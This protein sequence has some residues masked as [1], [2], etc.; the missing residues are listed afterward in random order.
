METLS[1]KMKSVSDIWKRRSSVTNINITPEINSPM[2]PAKNA[3]VDL[4]AE[5]YD[6][7]KQLE[8]KDKELKD[9]EQMMKDYISNRINISR[10]LSVEDQ[11]SRLKDELQKLGYAEPQIVR[12]A[13]PPVSLEAHR[14]LQT[15]A[16]NL[17][18]ALEKSERAHKARIQ[19]LKVSHAEEI[20]TLNLD[21]FELRD[22]LKHQSSGISENPG[23]SDTRLVI[24]LSTQ[25]SSL[26]SELEELREKLVKYERKSS[27]RKHAAERRK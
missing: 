19:K 5:I 26:T 24:E 1:V 16:A 23:I 13:T 20:A 11:I 6:L 7:K 14:R 27:A 15:E 8:D 3:T 25:V 12:P 17:K 22:Q 4:H 10:D 21:I 2:M 18:Q 9:Q